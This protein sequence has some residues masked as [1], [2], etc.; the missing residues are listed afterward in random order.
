[1]ITNKIRTDLLLVSFTRNEMKYSTSKESLETINKG[2]SKNPSK[3]R[4]RNQ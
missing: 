4:Y 3:T 2:V 1:M